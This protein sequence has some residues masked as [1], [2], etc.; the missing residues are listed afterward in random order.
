[1]IGSIMLGTLLV[2]GTWIVAVALVILIGR[3][4]PVLISPTAQGS[5]RIRASIWWGLGICLS[6]I[7]ALSLVTPLHSGSAAA[8]FAGAAVVLIALG[9]VLARRRG[10]ADRTTMTRGA[11]ALGISLVLVVA[12]LAFKALG[13]ATNY[14]TGLY[15]LGAIKYAGDY[16]T[17]PGLA[18]LYFPFGYN[19]SLFP[20]AAILGN[21]P[22]EG[23]GYRLVHIIALNEHG[24]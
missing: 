21:G 23:I 8:G 2:L 1:M 9:Y 7:L 19:N 15:H 5:A 18:H 17:I 4:V 12:Y 11:W 3:F 14:D 6:L 22:W 10:G 16:A 20:L 24:V 13:P